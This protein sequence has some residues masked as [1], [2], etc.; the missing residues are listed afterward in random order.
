VTTIT[1]TVTQY[2]N[3]AQTAP[4]ERETPMSKPIDPVTVLHGHTSEETAYLVDDYPYGYRLR[5]KIRYWI[6]T[7]TKG[8]AKGQSRFMSQTTNPKQ[9]G[10]VWNKPKASTYTP[11]A[12]MYLDTDNHVQWAGTGTN[13]DPAQDARLRLM[14]IVGQLRDTDRERYEL[15]LKLSQK[16]QPRWDEFNQRVDMIAAYLADSGADDIETDNGFWI[17]PGG[18]SVYLSGDPDVYVAVARTRMGKP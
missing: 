16:Y 18:Q 2:R 10:E 7:A 6:E 11:F 13:L 4:P 9:P 5:C 17:K 12:V 3:R 14:G 1:E 8:A 15:V